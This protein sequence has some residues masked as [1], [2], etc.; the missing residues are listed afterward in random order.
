MG[1]IFAVR[2]LILF[3]CEQTPK[4]HVGLADLHSA[5]SIWTR[6]KDNTDQRLFQS[7]RP[8]LAE[9]DVVLYIRCCSISHISSGPENGLLAT[10]IS[11]TNFLNI[12]A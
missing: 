10:V 6:F 11:G 5:G 12:G 1:L 2:L 4:L 7:S 9:K 8:L 3:N